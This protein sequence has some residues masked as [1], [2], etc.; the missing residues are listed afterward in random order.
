MTVFI[1]VFFQNVP[2]ADRTGPSGEGRV[3]RPVQQEGEGARKKGRR[4]WKEGREGE[5]RRIMGEGGV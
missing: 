3:L 1:V 2:P 4:W 5:G